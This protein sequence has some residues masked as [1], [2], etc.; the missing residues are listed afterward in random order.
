MTC[1]ARAAVFCSQVSYT[2]QCTLA[3]ATAI[4]LPTKAEDDFLLKPEDLAAAI[5]SKTRMIIMCNPSCVFDPAVA[6]V[7][8]ASYDHA[9]AHSA[10]GAGIRLVLF[11]RQ[12]ISKHS[13]LCCGSTPTC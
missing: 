11:T 8:P 7:V 2:E 3:G 10:I 6:V 12:N 13:Q 5:T 4:V 1:R 9:A